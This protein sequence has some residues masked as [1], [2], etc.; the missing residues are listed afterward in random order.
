MTLT[1]PFQITQIPS[2][3]TTILQNLSNRPN[4]L[5]TLII[6]RK[7]GCIIH[8]TGLASQSAFY[9]SPDFGEHL[10]VPMSSA[11]GQEVD[12]EMNSSRRE[13]TYTEKLTASILEFVNTAVVLGS[14]LEVSHSED[15]SNQKLDA[16]QTQGQAQRLVGDDDEGTDGKEQEVQLLRLRTRRQEIII[17]PDANYLCCVVQNAGKY[18]NS[19]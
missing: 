2:S 4:V 1:F 3:I 6:S 15:G 9:Q 7:D 8:A 16:V 17:F 13:P 5:C 14:T 12:I 11:Q 18:A 10:Q 19:R